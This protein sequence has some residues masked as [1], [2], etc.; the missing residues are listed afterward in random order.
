MTDNKKTGFEIDG[1]RYEVPRLDT[2]DLDEEYILW[3]YAD[4]VI[5]D[6]ADPHPDEK[7]DVKHALRVEQARKIRNPAFK[8]ALAHIAYRREHRDLD[9]QT[10]QKALGGVNA[11]ELD[12]AILRG[13]ASDPPTTDSQKPPGNETASSEPSKSSDSGA[14]TA[15][16]S[17]PAVVSLART[18]TTG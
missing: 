17:G 15:S 12:L 2:I 18:G 11:L 1:T 6:F 5:A 16:S 8:R 9:D 14:A 7:D 3:V 4:T 13:D 10:I